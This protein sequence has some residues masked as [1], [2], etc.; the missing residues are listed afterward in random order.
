MTK[1]QFVIACNERLIDPSVAL[2][3]ESLAHALRAGDNEKVI[4]ILDNEF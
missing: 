2:E 1:S 3:N 4:E